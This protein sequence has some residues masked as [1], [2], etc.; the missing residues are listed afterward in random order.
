M[1]DSGPLSFSA[2]DSEQS[3]PSNSALRRHEGRGAWVFTA[4]GISGRALFRGSGL[5]FSDFIAH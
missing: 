5:L 2:T 4:Y 1:E 3:S